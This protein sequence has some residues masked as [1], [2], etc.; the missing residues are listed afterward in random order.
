MCVCV[1]VELSS[2]I[3]HCSD[4]KAVCVHT[5]SLFLQEQ[6]SKDIHSSTDDLLDPEKEDT[7]QSHDKNSSE[8][9]DSNMVDTSEEDV[10]MDD[11]I[12]LKHNKGHTSKKIRDFLL[13]L[14]TPLTTITNGW[15]IYWKQEIRLVGFSMA[16]IY[17]T[18]LGFSGVTSAYFV[19]QGLRVD[20]IG[21]FQGVGAIFGVLGTLGYP[22]IRQRVGTVRTGLFGISTQLFILM[23]CVAAVILGYF[24]PSHRIVSSG[25][26][27]Y[28]SPNCNDSSALISVSLVPMS[29]HVQ[30]CVLPTKTTSFTMTTGTTHFTMAT[31]QMS[32]NLSASTTMHSLMISPTKT[33]SSSMPT[34]YL[35]EITPSPSSNRRR[36]ARNANYLSHTSQVTCHTPT[37]SQPSQPNGSEGGVALALVFMLIGVVCCRIGLW[38]F[39][40]AV[41][42]LVQEKVVEEERG[43]VS[44]VMGAM[45]SIM[46]MLHY[47][48]VIAAP[49]PEHFGI[50]ALISVAMI[51]V[52]WLL[53]ALYVR[54]ARGHFFHFSDYKR[55]GR[56]CVE[57]GRGESELV[58]EEEGSTCLVNNMAEEEQDGTHQDD[59]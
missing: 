11:V 39:D 16:S 17:L 48:L 56:M 14:V 25:S 31:Q 40:L 23:S 22:F 50:L 30:Q 26:E 57:R 10:L 15:K 27:G 41:Q 53:Y 54:K 55:K 42:Q 46:D 34:S 8:D 13:R 38:T 7:Q 36:F 43:V 9:K 21:V 5:H 4:T 51:A 47:V 12:D 3:P 52:G 35:L 33:Y 49:K 58:F 19:T 2:C 59:Q 24:H 37:P 29:T 32:Y 1:Y 18:V 45:N 44:G 6:S 28:Y 20:L